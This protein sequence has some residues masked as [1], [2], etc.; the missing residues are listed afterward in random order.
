MEVPAIIENPRTK[1]RFSGHILID[2]GCE[3]TV[4]DR[5]YAKMLG[6]PLAKT[7]EVLLATNADGSPNAEGPINECAELV[8]E[9]GN[10][11]RE[12]LSLVV[13]KFAKPYIYLG[14]DWLRKRNPRI[15]WVERTVDILTEVEGH[16]RT[17]TAR[18]QVKVKI[19]DYVQEFP[20]VFGEEVFDLQP[21]DRGAANHAIELLPNAKP[22]RSKI[23]AMP[24]VY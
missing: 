12:K 10:K 1:R 6:L 24:K 3:R 19:P 9:L 18:V 20:E 21:P 4:I 15:D 2:N 17:S 22:H 13:G 14:D 7:E 11:H 23:Y 8:L 5:E 16:T